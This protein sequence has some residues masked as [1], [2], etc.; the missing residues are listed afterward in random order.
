[1][2]E[3]SPAPLNLAL[4]ALLYSLITWFGMATY[5]KEVWLR[6]GEAFTTFFG[7]LGKFAPTEVRVTDPAVCAHCEADCRVNGA[8][9]NCYEC[10]ARATLEA[11]QI[12]LRPWAVG[13]LLPERITFDRL[14][15]IMLMLA[16]VTF[17]GLVL[18]PVWVT[19]STVTLPLTQPLGWVG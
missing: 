18:T 1:I 14:T 11:R 10:F 4:F 12:N 16:S 2:F 17:D 7:L 3:G 6:H 13:L 9:I 19:I 8:C 5:G 15:F